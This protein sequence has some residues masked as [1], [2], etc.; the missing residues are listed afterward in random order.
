MELPLAV[1]GE[2][3]RLL[4]IN[5]HGFIPAG[6]DLLLVCNA[7]VPVGDG[8]DTGGIIAAEEAV[9]PLGQINAHDVGDVLPHGS[10]RHHH[11]QQ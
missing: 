1:F 9:Q 5:V 4:V 2:V 8:H 3:H 11:Q 6:A 7:S 10:A